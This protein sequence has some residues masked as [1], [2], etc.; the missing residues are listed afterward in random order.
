MRKR[1]L[2]VLGAALLVGA[3]EKKPEAGGKVDFVRDIKPLFAQHCLKCH[4]GVKKKGQFRIDSRPAAMKG[5]ISGPVILPGK[6]AGSLMVQLLLSKDEEERMPKNAPALG[7][8]QVELVRRWID[9]GADWPDAASAGDAKIRHWAYQKPVKAE[10]PRVTNTQW[11]RTPIDAFIAADHEKRGLKPRPEAPRATLLRR[12][13]LDL[14]GLPPTREETRAFLVDAS[15]DA[16]EKIVDRLLADPRYGERWGRHWMDVWRYSDWAGYQKEVRESQAHIWRWRDWIVE[17]LNADKGYDRMVTEMLAGD[18][19]APEDPDTLRATGFLVRNWYKFNRNS[20]LINTVEHTAKA[21]LGTTMNCARCHDHFFDPITQEEYFKF[22]AFFEPHNIRTDRVPGATD[23]AADGVARVFDAE[24][25]ALTHLFVRGNEANPD[26]SKAIPP[27]VPAEL[28][29]AG[30]KIEEI[31]LPKLAFT[32]DKRGFVIHDDV[33]ASEKSVAEAR[34]KLDATLQAV[35]KT[36]QAAAAEG[37]T[38]EEMAKLK[39][40]AQA[41]LEELPLAQMAI[42]I[43]DAKHAA[44]A[45]AIRAETLEDAGDDWKKVAEEACTLQRKQALLEAQRNRFVAQRAVTKAV[46]AEKKDEKKSAEAKQKLEEAEKSLAKAEAE[47]KASAATAY[48]KRKV[49]VHPATSTGRRLALA[50]WITSRDNPLAARVAANHL[51]LRHFGKPIVG[52]VFN[53]GNNGRRPTHPA[54]LD[55][56]AVELMDQ[57]WSLKKMHRLILVSSVYRMDSTAD[58]SDLA[59]DPENAWLWRMNARRMEAEVVRDSVLYAAGR[60]DPARGGPDL[61]HAQGLVS[62][63]RSLYFR[64]AAEKQMEFLEIFDAA[65]VSECYERSESIIPQQALALANSTLVLEQARALAAALSKE[66]G[67]FTA[68]A[69]E[70][71]LGRAPGAREREECVRF[72]ETQAALLADKAKLT[73]FVATGGAKTGPSADPAQ[74]AREDLVHVLFNHNEFVTVR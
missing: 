12:V 70:A 73:P 10:P 41:A 22:R 34:T 9:Q 25:A 24:P 54:L 45:A 47:T 64:H 28:G 69:Y 48:A 61:D 11:A 32:P 57:G 67:D 3:Q 27:G 16:Y 42:P 36:E 33:A 29:T 30:L 17:S 52:S 68:A 21:F 14:I 7:A 59:A 1:V 74:R 37:K 62:R 50:R 18:E 20:W 13:Y 35:A 40:A 71:V 63:R 51:W 39:A 23:T 6:G 55:W 44:F 72:L 2:A 4:D 46:T 31:A 38:T 8:A 15:P 19:V 60:L 26:K 53:F 49:T 58:A 5:G 65:N 56:L 66:G 43:A